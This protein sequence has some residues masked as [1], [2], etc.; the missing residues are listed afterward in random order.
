[1]AW[2]FSR[3]ILKVTTLK[4]KIIQKTIEKIIIEI[5]LPPHKSG[6]LGFRVR[7]QKEPKAIIP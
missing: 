6:T 4:I 3:I 5:P 1:L 2:W 7:L